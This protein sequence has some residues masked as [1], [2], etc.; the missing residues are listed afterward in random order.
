MRIILSGGG[1]ESRELRRLYD[2]ALKE[3]EDLYIASAYL[4]EW[5]PK[6]KL[7]SACRK[8][9]FVV[10]R[11]FGLTRKSAMLSVLTCLPK[12]VSSFFAA[13]T[14]TGFH[15]KIVAWKTGSGKH[16]CIVGSSNL[17]RAGFSAN[18]EANV[19]SPISAREFERL[20]IWIDSMDVTPITEEWIADHYEEAQR[21]RRGKVASVPIQI[22]I[23]LLP[24]SSSCAQSVQKRRHNQKAF[25]NIARRLRK[26]LTHYSS[27]SVSEKQFWQHFWRL[28]RSSP[29]WR[30]QGRGWEIR[31][32]HAPWRQACAALVRII[33]AGKALPKNQLDGLVA[34]EIDRLAKAGNSVRGAWL[35]EMLCHYFPQRYP[36]DNR[37]VQKWWSY[38]KLPYRR[39]TTEGQ[40]YAELAQKLRWVLCKYKPAGARDLA[41]LDAAIHCCLEEQGL[42]KRRSA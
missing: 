42:L 25:T 19:F 3:A 5:D 21:P 26:L 28:Y 17:S 7:G 31:G 39:G 20:R 8:L 10:G 30:L 38:N 18:Y 12:G 23:K 33:E 29:S 9:V 36:V 22:K 6:W 41:E 37:P 32:K 13:D 16:Y 15:P 2:R 4:T 14:E 1:K 35:S 11:D 27:G 34:S 40:K 24:N